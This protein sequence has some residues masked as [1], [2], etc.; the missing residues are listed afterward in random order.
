MEH[1]RL[2]WFIVIVVPENCELARILILRI[3]S[4]KAWI[5]MWDLKSLSVLEVC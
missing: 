3:I 2:V 5:L 4:M 1:W